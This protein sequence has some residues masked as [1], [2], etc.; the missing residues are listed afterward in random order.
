MNRE[1]WSVVCCKLGQGRAGQGRVG[2]VELDAVN[3]SRLSKEKQDR[4]PSASL[5][6]L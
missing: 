6:T 1:G 3:S 2:R 5:C 4:S